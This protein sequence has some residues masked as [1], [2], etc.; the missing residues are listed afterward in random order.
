MDWWWTSG[1]LEVGWLWVG[2][3]RVQAY[4]LQPFSCKVR[5]EDNGVSDIPVNNAA[6]CRDAGNSAPQSRARIQNGRVGCN[7][8]LRNSP[9]AGTGVVL[10]VD[11]IKSDMTQHLPGPPPHIN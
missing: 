2:C 5:A 3:R 4:S 11:L 7:I 9:M 1:G 6:A 8:P 10:T